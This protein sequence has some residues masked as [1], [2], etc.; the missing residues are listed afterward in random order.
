MHKGNVEKNIT[1][2]TQEVGKVGLYL[3]FKKTKMILC[4]NRYL[5]F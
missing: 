5:V 4:L 3:K 2:L 1:E